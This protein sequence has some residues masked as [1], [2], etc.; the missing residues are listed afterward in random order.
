MLCNYGNLINTDDYVNLK[1]NPSDV[2]LHSV[3]YCA[4]K[5]KAS[6]VRYNNVQ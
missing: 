1:R 3:N 2:L 4:C 5:F 6:N